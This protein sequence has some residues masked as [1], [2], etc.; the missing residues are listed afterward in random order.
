MRQYSAEE[1]ALLAA[2]WLDIFAPN[3]K[4]A[5]TKQFLWHIFS[6]GRSPCLTR[7][8]ARNAYAKQAAAEFIVLSNDRAF[9]IETETLPDRCSLSD[10]YVFPRNFAWTFAVTHEDGWLDGPYFAQHR[11]YAI[12][13]AANLAMVKKAAAAQAARQNGWSL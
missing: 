3:R 6:A 10:Y 2:K 13:N 12:L 1:A 5:G 7:E 4:G 11:D 8:E 9:A